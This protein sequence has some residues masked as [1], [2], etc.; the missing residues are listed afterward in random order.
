MHGTGPLA[1]S[2][3][4]L[5]ADTSNPNYTCYGKKLGKVFQS[6]HFVLKFP[7]NRNITGS[8]LLNFNLIHDR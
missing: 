8:M 6:L 5:K 1:A 3:N 7:Y 2:M 4:D